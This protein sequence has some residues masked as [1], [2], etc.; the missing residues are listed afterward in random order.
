MTVRRIRIKK[1]RKGQ[2]KQYLHADMDH[3]G[4]TF[5]YRDYPTLGDWLAARNA[6]KRNAN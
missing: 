2:K 1:T 3:R 4:T 5:M 6:R